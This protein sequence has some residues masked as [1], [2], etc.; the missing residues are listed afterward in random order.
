[1]SGR[2]PRIG[3]GGGAAGPTTAI[4]RPNSRVCRIAIA[5]VTSFTAVGLAL[6]LD[7]TGAGQAPDATQPARHRLTSAASIDSRGAVRTVALVRVGRNIRFQAWKAPL[8]TTV[9]R[10]V[11]GLCNVNTATF[12]NDLPGAG[13]GRHAAHFRASTSAGDTNW[14]AIT[15]NG[16]ADTVTDTGIAFDT[17]GHEFEIEFDDT[18]G[19]VKFY[20]DGTLVATHT[21]TLPSGVSLAITVGANTLEAVAKSSEIAWVYLESDL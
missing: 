18:A 9:V 6:S 8:E 4:L 17:T 19:E 3:A 1:M 5:D 13:G 21:T 15:S 12:Q 7:G 2:I 14:Q 10:H 11:V 20:I 16:A